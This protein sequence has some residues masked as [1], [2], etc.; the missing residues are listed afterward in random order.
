MS[1]VWKNQI[2]AETD[3]IINDFGQNLENTFTDLGKN[4]ISIRI[5]Y[6]LDYLQ[7]RNLFS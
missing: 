4:S 5:L 6:Y 1:L 7:I 3:E 2:M